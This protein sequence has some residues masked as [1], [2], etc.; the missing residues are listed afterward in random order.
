[1]SKV[2]R[3]V[4]VTRP[5][6]YESLIARHGTRE[7]AR[8]FSKT[9][10]VS[11]DEVEARHR[12]FERAVQTLTQAIPTAWR[13][14]RL[15]RADLAQF[16]FEPD[17][18]VAAVGQDG[19]VANVAKYLS[20]QL[21]IGLNPEPEVHPGVLV[22]HRPEQA[23]SLLAAAA[24]GNCP[25][26]TRTMV[27]ARLPDGQR[28]LALNEVFVGHTSHQSARYRLRCGE[29]QERHSSSGLIV[30]T[31]TGATG[32]ALSI[33]RQ[34]RS[35]CDL[36]S[37][38]EPKLA[39][40]VRE[41]WPSIATGTNLSSG[42]LDGDASLELVSEMN[43]GGTL[44]GDGIEQDRIELPWG[45]RVILRIAPERLRVASRKAA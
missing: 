6:D 9:R 25:V 20:G 27:E 21:V 26:Q 45:T 30:S 22:R 40:F 23:A 14:I 16:V 10:G 1:M 19:L 31:G 37:P 38:E 33:H 32:W 17:D 29:Q 42:V 7:Q 13:R 15:G 4:V 43:E 8:F 11:L 5:T 39:F 18:I 41:P 28:L 34:L 3:V 24:A 12:R 35:A 2:P 36:P 44:F